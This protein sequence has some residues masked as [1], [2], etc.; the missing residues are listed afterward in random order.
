MFSSHNRHEFRLPQ[1]FSDDRQQYT[2]TGIMYKNSIQNVYCWL[3]RTRVKDKPVAVA[4]RPS[5]SAPKDVAHVYAAVL[6]YVQQYVWVHS[7]KFVGLGAISSF[8]R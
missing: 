2:C 6:A 1:H 8:W 4:R 3:F 7:S 5:L